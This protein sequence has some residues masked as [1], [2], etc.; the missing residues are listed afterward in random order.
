MSFSNLVKTQV[1][2]SCARRCC[3][4]GK[5]CGTKIE[6]H[7]IEPKAE[8]GEDSYE[9]AIPL[10]F[11]CHA[12]A[13]HYNANHPKG[14]KYTRP[15]LIRHRDRMY[16]LVAD[17]IVTDKP[18][19]LM[20]QFM[21]TERF[22]I[23]SEIA[24]GDFSNLPIDDVRVMQNELFKFLKQ[25]SDSYSGNDRNT[26]LCETTYSSIEEY[27]SKYHISMP[28][29][30]GNSNIDEIHRDI[31]HDEL[32]RYRH[33]DKLL[34]HML[35]IGLHPNDI[36]YVTYVEAGCGE[37]NV[38]TML[39]K[40]VQVVF[41]V[42]TNNEDKPLLLNSMDEFFTLEGNLE[43]LSSIEGVLR[44]QD[45]NLVPLQSKHSLL[46]PYAIVM[47]ST[48]RDEYSECG[49]LGEEFIYTDLKQSYGRYTVN[50]IPEFLAVGPVHKINTLGVIFEGLHVNEPIRDVA[51]DKTFIISRFWCCG[52]CPHIFIKKASCYQWEYLGELFQGKP[53]DKCVYTMLLD[54]EN[55]MDT[56][57]VHIIELEDEVTHIEYLFADGSK[58]I[59]NKELQYGQSITLSVN[60]FR[61]LIVRGSYSLL[62][63]LTYHDDFNTKM[64]KTALYQSVL[65]GIRIQSN[66]TF[67]S[68]TFHDSD[69]G[70]HLMLKPIIKSRISK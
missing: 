41:A 39:L 21:I 23:V 25:L 26:L 6:I 37:S 18:I 10:C 51:L 34:N 38:E 30:R 2:V 16:K 12:D 58:M 54:H 65:N 19:N 47:P 9:N 45:L 24:N 4:C 32:C 42:I 5:F 50:P 64:Q 13:G 27:S 53:D 57:Y 59:E 15:E 7:H 67:L 1:L 33:N 3:V 52:S 46:I 14:T 49:V 66:N 8:G 43:R 61:K 68:K 35:E 28:N 48:S 17:G 56:E 20:T 22:D 36:A 69:I 62:D 29:L 60:G 55:L 11:D 70:T 63:G 40:P 44:K 31:S